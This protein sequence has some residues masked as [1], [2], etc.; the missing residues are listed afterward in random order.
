MKRTRRNRRKAPRR[1]LPKLPR[2]P[3][4]P[5][6]SIDWG[7]IGALVLTLG[8]AAAI[9]AFGRELLEVPVRR[10]DADGSFQRVTKLEILAAAS[11]VVEDKTFLSVNLG[12]VR[13]RVAAIDW[14]DT[15]RVQRVW[16]DSLRIAFTEHRAAA[17]WGDRG[18]LNTRGELFAED[19][20]HEYLELP[21]LD[22]PEGS[23][24]RVAV[25]YLEIRERL[26]EASLVLDS[27]RMDARGAFTIDFVGGLSVRIGREHVSDRIDRFFTDVVPYMGGS[28]QRAAYIDMRYPSAFAVGWREATDTRL[29]RLDPRG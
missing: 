12:D 27:V 24:H 11:P 18:L 6:P 2:L 26:A 22:G 21:R 10:L 19:V 9:L 4:L 13:D 20:P 8:L 7:R 17:R 14:I 29:A 15:V 28:L 3:A 23:H 1:E 25:R 5:R 16:P